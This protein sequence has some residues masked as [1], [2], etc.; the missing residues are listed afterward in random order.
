MR[1]VLIVNDALSLGRLLKTTLSTL[2]P[3]I[4]VIVV[5][6]VEDAIL[7][8]TRYPLDLLITDIQIQEIQ[9]VDLINRI[10]SR[11]PDLRVIVIG[12]IFDDAHSKQVRALD[13]DAYFTKPLNIPEF[14]AA[15]RRF[16]GLD[17]S[18]EYQIGSEKDSEKRK[19]TP[20][21]VDVLSGFR[22]RIGSR[23]VLLA[24]GNGKIQAQAGNVDEK[25]FQRWTPGILSAI[26][27]STHLSHG[28]GKAVSESVIYSTGDNYDLMITPI[29]DVVLLA[30]LEKNSS[31]RHAQIFEELIEV[32]GVLEHIFREIGL[33]SYSSSLSSR[34]VTNGEEVT[35]SLGDLSISEDLSTL[36]EK[37][38]GSVNKKQVDTFWE[39]QP[40][41]S[42]VE[43][44]EP[45]TLSYDQAHRL[46]FTPEDS[47]EN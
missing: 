7:E 14:T 38:G 41:Q 3:T 1:H 39:S 25:S 45:D 29:Y 11:Q 35:S 16:L 27:A 37:I 8:G 9:R 36:F 15:A 33:A 19:P 6:S 17:D 28:L 26:D 32:R 44:N 23:A 5:S 30:V 40:G 12:G 2:D 34:E 42:T 18:K 21:L 20:N 13:A 4:P 47:E 46:G 43:P 31:T 24:G 10:R 22:H